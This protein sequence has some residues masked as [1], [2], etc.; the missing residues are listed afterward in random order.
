MKNKKLL[1]AGLIFIVF[2]FAGYNVYSYL[3][4]QEKIEIEVQRVAL[5]EKQKQLDL[6]KVRRAR[7]EEKKTKR[8]AEKQ[9]KEKAAKLLA[10]EK[11][12]AQLEKQRQENEKRETRRLAALELKKKKAAD[13]LEKRVKLAR[14][15]RSIEGIKEEVIAD[16]LA[17]SPQYFLDNAEAISKERYKPKSFGRYTKNRI[18]IA[19]NT[20]ALMIYSA[21][22]Q[23][24]EQIGA[25]LKA[26]I[27]IN[28]VNDKGF[29]AVHF[30]AAYNT[31]EIVNYLI[32]QGANP[33]VKSSVGDLSILHIASFINPRPAMTEL[34]VSKKIPLE[35]KS[36]NGYTPLLIAAESNRNIEVAAA[37]ANLGADKKSYVENGLTAYGLVRRRVEDGFDPEYFRISN[38]LDKSTLDALKPN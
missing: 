8:L 31:P 36:S 32:E 29:S 14:T 16:M 13:K 12:L 38:D 28:E 27:G 2:C 3:Q 15:P 34:L 5:L 35:D 33:H 11:R 24:I 23:N 22:S 30:A 19:K 25:L 4:E 6:E 21:A 7:E 9:A 20:N 1:F 17:I 18:L 37:L 10:E 26:G